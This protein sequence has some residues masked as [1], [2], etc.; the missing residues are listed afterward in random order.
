MAIEI[1][2]RACRVDAWALEIIVRVFLGA[3]RTLEIVASV[4]PSSRNACL[5]SCSTLAHP[6]H[7]LAH[8]LALGS[9]LALGLVLAL[10]YA[11]ALVSALVL[12]AALAAASAVVALLAVA[13][14]A[15][16]VDN[17]V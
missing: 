5:C 7:A 16:V 10:A 2:V 1:A 9:T 15:V 4:C 12:A 14:A 6:A 3:V 11:S 13:V 17:D 8:A